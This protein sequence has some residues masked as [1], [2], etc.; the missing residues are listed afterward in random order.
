MPFCALLGSP[1]SGSNPPRLVGYRAFSSHHTSESPLNG[2]ARGCGS[3]PLDPPRSAARQ[4]LPPH[5]VLRVLAVSGSHQR[6]SCPPRQA[7]T[8]QGQLTQWGLS[9]LT[10]H[11]VR[12]QVVSERSPPVASASTRFRE[13]LPFSLASGPDDA[14]SVRTGIRGKVRHDSWTMRLE[15]YTSAAHQYTAFFFPTRDPPRKRRLSGWT[16]RVSAWEWRW[17]QTLWSPQTRTMVEFP[18]WMIITRTTSFF[19]IDGTSSSSQPSVSVN[20]VESGNTSSHARCSAT[21]R[22][23]GFGGDCPEESCAVDNLGFLKHGDVFLQVV[24][25][26]VVGRLRL[27]EQVLLAHSRCIRVFTPLALLTEAK[28]MTDTSTQLPITQRTADQS[29]S[30]SWATPHTR[31]LTPHT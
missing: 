24:D 17:R 30:S 6:A 21:M 10:S 12:C 19:T 23:Q 29:T 4:E 31:N 7:L 15:K 3:Q 26:V 1:S 28:E 16:R 8:Y 20:V 13:F 2:A 25:L 27:R 22:S 11:G 5:E 9:A 14:E 18:H